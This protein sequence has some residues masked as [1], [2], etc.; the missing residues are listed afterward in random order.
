MQIGCL[1]HQCFREA[2]VIIHGLGAAINLAVD[3]ALSIVKRSLG[4]LV[5]S[6]TT[7]TEPL[8]D[9]FEPISPVLVIFNHSRRQYTNCLLRICLSLHKCDTT[10]LFTSKFPKLSEKRKTN[11]KQNKTCT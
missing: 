3:L 9:D 5:A 6:P 1:I 4:D 11:L 10:P 8:I 2:E 7:S